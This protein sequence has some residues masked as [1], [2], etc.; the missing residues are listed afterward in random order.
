MRIREADLARDRTAFLAFITGSQQYEYAF[1]PNRRL[2]PPVADEY[3]A[4]T[5]TL[6]GERAGQIFVAADDADN[7]VGWSIVVEQDDDIFVVAEERRYAYIAELFVVE[8]LRGSG[9]GRALIAA[10]EDWSRAHGL[11]V[12]QIGVL[13]GNARAH[14][15]YRRQGYADYGIQLRKYLR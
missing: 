7:A 9:V 8:S 12:M 5:L 15:I 4:K 10:C 13:S 14:D 6:L 2:D 1:E 11:T 3:L